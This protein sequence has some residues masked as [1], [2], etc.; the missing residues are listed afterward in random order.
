LSLC[1]VKNAPHSVPTVFDSYVTKVHVGDEAVRLEPWDIARQEDL[2][3]IPL[4]ST[5]KTDILLVCFS[6]VEKAPLRNVQA[7]WLPELK[8]YVKGPRVILAGTRNGLAFGRLTDGRSPSMVAIS[9]TRATKPSVQRPASISYPV[10]EDSRV[11][12][13][14]IPGRTKGIICLRLGPEYRPVG[15]SS[16]ESKVQIAST[17]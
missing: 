14:A 12:G 4:L 10:N 7:K 1:Q 2:K 3:N 5:T 8:R 15:S 9:R 17:T 16:G 13:R 11:E 6:M